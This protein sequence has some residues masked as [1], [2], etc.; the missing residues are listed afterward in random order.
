MAIVRYGRYGGFCCSSCSARVS[1]GWGYRA[2]LI[3][4]TEEGAYMSFV[5]P[6]TAAALSV[7]QQLRLFAGK[8]S[9]RGRSASGNL[10]AA[11]PAPSRPIGKA[12]AAVDFDDDDYAG[13]RILR[14]YLWMHI[15]AG[16]TITPLLF[17]GLAGLL[18]ND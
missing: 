13:A 15:L 2:R 1:F 16:W 14:W 4:P 6:G 11:E 3:T 7:F 12:T 10:L 17:A 5:R 8:F 9:A 18:R